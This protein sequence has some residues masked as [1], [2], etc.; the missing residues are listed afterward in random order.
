MKNRY[1]FKKLDKGWVI[2]D[3]VEK[4]AI[5]DCFHSRYYAK[6]QFDRIKD[7]LP[8]Y[9]EKLSYYERNKDKASAYGK[10]YRKRIKLEKAKSR[11]LVIATK[12]Q[13]REEAYKNLLSSWKKKKTPSYVP[14]EPTK[15]SCLTCGKEFAGRSNRKYCR[16]KCSPSYKEAKRLRKRIGRNTRPRWASKKDIANI[17]NNKPENGHVDHIVPLNH[18]DVSGLHVPWNLQY[19]TEEENLL[20]GN[21]FDY[22]NENNGWRQILKK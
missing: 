1:S 6:Y 7:T 14:T 5:S 19:L 16:V 11:D 3:K 4:C 8:P 15:N 9:S 17:Y 13:A 21:K 22:T 10:E 12:K 2:W 18:P 20:K